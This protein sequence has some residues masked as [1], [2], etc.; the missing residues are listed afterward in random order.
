[1]TVVRKALG[2]WG[3]RLAAR[4]DAVELRRAEDVVEAAQELHEHDGL[5]AMD[6]GLQ[7]LVPDQAGRLPEAPA[8]ASGTPVRPS[9]FAGSRI[10][11]EI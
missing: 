2:A 8:R 1:M 10:N 9:T 3:E 7:A 5:P 6:D 4:L 11:W